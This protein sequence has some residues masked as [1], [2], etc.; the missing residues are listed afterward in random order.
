MKA[1]MSRQQSGA[2][3]RND[4]DDGLGYVETKRNKTY[5]AKREALA[6]RMLSLAMRGPG[7]TS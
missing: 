7:R 4:D 1:L 2:Y 3:R 6:S 5:S